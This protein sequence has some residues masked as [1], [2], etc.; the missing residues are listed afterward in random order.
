MK[1]LFAML[2]AVAPCTQVQEDEPNWN[3]ETMG[4]KVCGSVNVEVYPEGEDQ[5]IRIWDEHNRLVFGPVL[6]E[7]VER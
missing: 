2:L 7:G 5:F 6:L 4:N 1:Y 3:C